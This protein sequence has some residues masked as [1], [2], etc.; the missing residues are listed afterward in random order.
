MPITVS[1]VPPTGCTSTVSTTR[2]HPRTAGKSA[3]LLAHAFFMAVYVA[4][5]IMAFNSVRS[6][7]NAIPTTSSKHP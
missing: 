6:A 1:Y 5:A 2:G 7:L 3:W 4:G